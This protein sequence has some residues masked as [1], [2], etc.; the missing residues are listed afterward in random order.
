[1]DKLQK[2]RPEIQICRQPDQRE[3]KLETGKGRKLVNK[4]Q[5]RAFWRVITL[6]MKLGK[7]FFAN[8]AQRMHQLKR[9][10]RAG[11]N[12]IMVVKM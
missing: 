7:A 3:E 5:P 11:R 8:L 4:S 12:R 9:G 1:M 10:T 6:P 2:A